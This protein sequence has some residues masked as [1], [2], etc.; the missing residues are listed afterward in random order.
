[1][2]IFYFRNMI[3][4]NTI[5]KTTCIIVL[6]FGYYFLMAIP[7]SAIHQTLSS[8]NSQKDA[9]LLIVR[10]FT[11]NNKITYLKNKLDTGSTS[12]KEKISIQNQYEEALDSR[13][14]YIHR[15][16]N[17][18][19]EHFT[20]CDI[21]FIPDT[22]FK[23]HLN[24]DVVTFTNTTGQTI[25]SIQKYNK[26]MYMLYDDDE[27]KIL[28]H[29]SDGNAMKSPWPFRK[30]TIFPTIKRLIN[31]NNYLDS[32]IKWFDEKLTKLIHN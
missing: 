12:D 14:V 32:Q 28:L 19:K 21:L 15:L 3:K 18:F 23:D 20:V 24:G 25:S 29:D 8:T 30:N 1:M 6:C 11:N 27:Y 17:G 5:H 22:L 26:I 16:T 31:K 4:N 9:T 10:V 13:N 2:I 7:F